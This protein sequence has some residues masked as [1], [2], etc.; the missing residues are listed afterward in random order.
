M[1]VTN[2]LSLLI[3]AVLFLLCYVNRKKIFKEFD[4]FIRRVALFVFLAGFVIYFIGFRSGHE[5]IGTQLSWYASFFRPLLSALEMFALHSDLIEVGEPCHHSMQ[6][7]PYPLPSPSTIWVFASVLPGVGARYVPASNSKEM[8]ML[9]SVSMRF[10]WDWHKIFIGIM[11][12]IPSSSSMRLRIPA[13]K[14]CWGLPASSMCSVLEGKSWQ[15]LT[16]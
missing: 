5:T 3:T 1:F 11:Q 9:S 14:A 16:A 13:V 12:K 4:T 6:L 2:L 10:L 8:C 15:K 7:Q